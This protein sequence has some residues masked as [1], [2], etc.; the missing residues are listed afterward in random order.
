MTGLGYVV[1]DVTLPRI[2]Y[3]IDRAR[4]IHGIHGS[5]EFWRLPFFFVNFWAR[6]ALLCQNP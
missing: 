4:R 5:R 3:L 2:S 6:V 1:Y